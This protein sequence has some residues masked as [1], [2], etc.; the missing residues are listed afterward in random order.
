MVPSGVGAGIQAASAIASG[1]MVPNKVF[2]ALSEGFLV[3]N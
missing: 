3:R 2:H 1:E